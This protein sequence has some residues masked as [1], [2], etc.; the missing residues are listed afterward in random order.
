MEQDFKRAKEIGIQH[1]KTWLPAGKQAGKEWLAKNPNRADNKIG[2]F[3]VNL[4]T[5]LWADFAD[6]GTGGDVIDL[7]AYLNGLKPVEAVSEILN[8]PYENKPVKKAPSFWDDYSQIIEGIENPPELKTDWYQKNWGELKNIWDFKKDGKII[9]KVC[10][11][12]DDHGKKS[13]RPFTL[14]KKGDSVKWRAKGYTGKYSLWNQEELKKYPDKKIILTEGQKAASIIKKM[15]ND[16]ICLGWYGGAG[17]EKLTDWS[18]LSGKDVLFAYDNDE[19]GVKSITKIQKQAKENNF[20]LSI[21]SPPDYAPEKWDLGDVSGPEELKDI[22]DNDQQDQDPNGFTFE[23]LGY[24]GDHIVFYPH[25]IKRCVKHKATG[26]SKAVLMTLM[27][28]DQWGVFYAKSDGGIAWDTAAND[29]LRMAEK[30]PVFDF[31]MVRG[32]GAWEDNGKLIINTGEFLIIDG[33]KKE[34]YQSPG[35]FVYEK[36]K[37]HPYEYKNELSEKEMECIFE[38]LKTIEWE[39]NIHPYFLL[40]WLFLAAYGGALRWRPHLWL[41]G[42]KG[43]GKSWILDNIVYPLIGSRFSVLAKGSSTPAGVRS[44]LGNSSLPTIMD[45]MESDNNR[46]A[47]NIDQILK[48]FRESASGK[49]QTAATLHGS[50]DGEGRIWLVQSMALFASIGAGLK[51]GADKSRFTNICLKAP[52]KTDI[53]DREINFKKI[54]KLSKRI[55][56][57]LGVRFV[58]LG[59]SLFHEIEKSVI[60]FS[61]VCTNLI[62]NRRD[63]DQIGTLLAGAW[64]ALNREAP[65]EEDAIRFVNGLHLKS[66][67]TTG[68]EKLDEE[69]CLDEILSY[70]LD[71]SCSFKIKK[72]TIGSALSF[73]FSNR[74]V[75]VVSDDTIFEIEDMEAIKNELALNGIKPGRNGDTPVLQIAVSHPAV[76]KILK[77]SAWSAMYDSLLTR[78][79]FSHDT[80]KGPSR[81]GGIS[82]RFVEIDAVSIF[83]DIPF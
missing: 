49:G 32:A 13:D 14:Y 73:Y 81:F 48:M 47:E 43:T 46:Y 25:G 1:I 4:D 23:I 20:N 56:N 38:I 19:A 60:I 54:D 17:N 64:V 63:G 74:D 44:G 35:R 57:D 78:L 79:P 66:Y 62:L 8:K 15:T 53:K 59:Y 34:L 77:E 42:P 6:P 50:S 27:D 21:I 71:F 72:A 52:G 70:K 29:V 65:T 11:F 33:E 41:T 28:R 80:V 37:L 7:Y 82:K 75:H 22:I 55:T 61:D 31:T 83:E 12:I 45:E 40:G 24:N 18:V 39:A 58:S 36:T 5:G 76:R 10:R 2:S 16:F 26:L 3:S 67:F 51:H 9:F 30:K 69:L 68:Q